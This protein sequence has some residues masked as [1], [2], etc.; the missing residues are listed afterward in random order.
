MLD[1]AYATH[2][3]EI[4]LD[5][6]NLDDIDVQGL[7]VLFAWFR[8][9]QASGASFYVCGLCPTVCARLENSGLATVLPLLP[10]EAFRGPRPFLR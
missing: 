8:K 9:A 7:R 6:E 1:E 5:C 4:W 2:A 3:A 10:T